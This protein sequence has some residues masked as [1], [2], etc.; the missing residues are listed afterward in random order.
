MTGGVGAVPRLPALVEGTVR[1]RRRGGV[2]HGFSHR[3]YQWLV[4]LDHLPRLPLLLRPFAS[5]DSA[6]HLGDPNV[7][8]KENVIAFLRLD[9]V[10]VTGG[11]VLM[12]ANARVLGH[13]FDPL[14][15]FWCFD[16]TGVLRCVLAEVHNT[17]GERHVY[18]LDVDD[19]GAAHTDKEF[20][21]SPFFTVDGR[22]DLRFT[23]SPDLVTTTV[24][25][26]QGGASVFTAT[27]TGR[28]RPLG[29]RRLVSVLV[30]R[31]FMTQ[32]ISALIRVH[33]LWLW[34][35]R[36]PIVRRPRHVP[37]EGVR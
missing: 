12:L 18:R 32:R 23:L 34:L 16:R 26:R 4:D 24:A 31:P 10:D 36:Q 15:V 11:R 8:I 33:G 9:G 13:V 14:S 20:Y 25:L 28:P 27:F 6:D 17:Y 3:V 5:F 29:T 37:Q 30:R 19:A 22:Y 2:Q 7:S 21:V 35:R 1:H